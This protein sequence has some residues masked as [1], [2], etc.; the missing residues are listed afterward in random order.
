MTPD[1]EIAAKIGASVVVEPL[2]DLCPRVTPALVGA[3]A[4]VGIEHGRTTGEELMLYMQSVHA[5]HP[6]GTKETSNE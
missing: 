6:A 4:S 2:C 5:R 1:N 3:C